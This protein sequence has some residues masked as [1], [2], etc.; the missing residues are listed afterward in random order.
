MVPISLTS[1]GVAVETTALID[2]GAAGNFI[3]INF[4]NSHNLPLVTCETRLAVT[5]LDGRPLGPGLVQFK[6]QVFT[7]KTGSLH[8][9]CICLFAIDSPQNP[10]I[11]GLPWLEKH[12]HV[13]PGP[14]NKSNNGLNSVTRM[15]AIPL[16][17]CEIHP[18]TGLR[19]PFHNESSCWISRSL[20][21]LQQIQSVT[22]ATTPIQ[23]LRYRPTSWS[24]ANER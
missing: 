8:I 24:N 4:A 16:P 14:L 23:R 17:W 19:N 20:G 6:T 9:E 5:A 21:G 2:S 3:D 12:N 15:S 7:L 13:F 11:L 10:V 1:A 18:F 22:A